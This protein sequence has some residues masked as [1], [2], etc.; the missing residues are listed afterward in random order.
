MV[1]MKSFLL[2]LRTLLVV[3]LLIAGVVIIIWALG[4]IRLL[5][6]TDNGMG[7]TIAFAILGMGVILTFACFIIKRR[8][9]TSSEKAKTEMQKENMYNEMKKRHPF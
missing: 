3:L 1:F 7:G 6:I 4:S 5:V 2:K 9:L 8:K